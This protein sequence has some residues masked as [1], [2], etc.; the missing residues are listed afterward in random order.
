MGLSSMI[1]INYLFISFFLSFI[2]SSSAIDSLEV[3]GEEEDGFKKYAT[4]EERKNIANTFIPMIKKNLLK[5]RPMVELPLTAV[6]LEVRIQCFH[7]LSEMHNVKYN[8]Y[9]YIS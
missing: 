2:Y 8:I 3:L 5:F 9:K 4:L 6:R 1:I 7:F